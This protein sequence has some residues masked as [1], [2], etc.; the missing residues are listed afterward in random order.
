[1]NPEGV[2]WLQHTFKVPPPPEPRRGDI[3]GYACAAQHIYH[4]FGVEEGEE[5][6][7]SYNHVTPSGFKRFVGVFGIDDRNMSRSL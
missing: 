1:M 3:D 7:S 6:S 2:A 5:A 4:P